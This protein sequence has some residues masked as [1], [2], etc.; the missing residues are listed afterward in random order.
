MYFNLV[1]NFCFQSWRF[2][3]FYLI[4]LSATRTPDSSLNSLK[5]KVIFVFCCPLLTTF[6]KILR[7]PE[8]RELNWSLFYTKRR[9]L[10]RVGDVA[11][12]HVK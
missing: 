3:R 8:I 7:T 2:F 4:N 5:A 9:F 12:I 6:G 11:A 10:T 1:A